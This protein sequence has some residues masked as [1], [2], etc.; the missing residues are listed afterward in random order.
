MIRMS[1]ILS[2]VIIRFSRVLPALFLVLVL[3]SGTRAQQATTAVVDAASIWNAVH[4]DTAFS[5]E[6][7]RVFRVKT[8][9]MEQFRGHPDLVLENVALPTGERVSLRLRRFTVFSD[10]SVVV[11]GTSRG[12]VRR[13]LPDVALYRGVV[14]GREQSW[15]Y[16]AVD[17]NGLS[18]TV[19]FAGREFSLDMLPSATS[20]LLI[21][22]EVIPGSQPTFCGITDLD[23]LATQS[24]SPNLLSK[25]VPGILVDTLLA[26]VA[27]DADYELFQHFAAW[28]RRRTTSPPASG[29]SPPSTSGTLPS[30]SRCRSC[31]SGIR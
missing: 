20:R 8:N 19:R 25:T 23:E 29:K 9:V 4:G 7:E 5:H 3:A 6:G 15:A 30:S 13:P 27:I 18:G 31:V 16:L 2:P 14:E 24:P 17:R 10:A 11:T 22:R 12:D 21:V 28:R 1:R 26:K